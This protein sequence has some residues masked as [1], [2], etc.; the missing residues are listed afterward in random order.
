MR[1]L[2]EPSADQCL[3]MSIGAPLVLG[4]TGQ[5]LPDGL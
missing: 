2:L 4:V 1:G 3:E 5:D